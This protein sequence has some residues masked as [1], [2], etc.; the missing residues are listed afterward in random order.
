MAVSELAVMQPRP[1][2]LF[3]TGDGILPLLYPLLLTAGIQPGKDIEIVSCNNEEPLLRE[4]HPRPVEI[5]LHTRLIGRRAVEQLLWRRQ[6][7]LAPRT[8]ILLAPELVQA[9]K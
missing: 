3:S 2:A 6:N 5:E 8:C 9:G 7:P 4:L 1:S